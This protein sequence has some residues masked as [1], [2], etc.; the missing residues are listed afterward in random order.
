MPTPRDMQLLTMDG[1]P[2]GMNNRARETEQ[3]GARDEQRIASSQFLRRALNVDL[4]AEGHPLRRK[5]YALAQAGFA[6]S[7]WS[8]QQLGLICWVLDGKLYVGRSVDAASPVAQVNKYRPMSFVMVNDSIYYSNAQQ[9][10]EIYYDGTVRN[11]GVPVAPA[12]TISG[13]AT[14]TPIGVDS[15]RQVTATYVDYF[16]REGGAGETVLVGAQGLFQ[17][18]IPMPHPAGVLKA[19]I[20]ASQPDSEILYKVKTVVAASPVN[21][22]DSDMGRGAELGTMHLRPPVAGQLLTHFNGRVYVARNDYVT[23]SEPLRYDLFRPSQGIYTFPDNVTLLEPSTDGIY[24]GTAS[25]TVFIAGMDPYDVRQMHVSPHKP[26]PGSVA[27]IPGSKMGLAEDT[28]PVWWGSDG[29]LVVGLPGGQ[30]RQLTQDRLAVAPHGAG[31]TTLREHNGMTHIVSSLRQGL[32]DAFGATDSVVAE[33][34]RNCI[35]L[36]T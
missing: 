15:A 30:L 34:R 1:W 23:F 7:V 21:I 32:G 26:I 33:V 20:Y 25:G 24:V 9:L 19:N 22:H 12:P 8:T 2:G 3:V 35:S 4:T 5:G 13:P 29:V 36:N 18:D 17:A 11:W 14:N 10:G 31:A 27:R 6:H 28:V 16:G